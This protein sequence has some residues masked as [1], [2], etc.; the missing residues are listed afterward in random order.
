[1]ARNSFG[2]MVTP[3]AESIE[4]LL[5]GS[6]DMHIHP[7][8][9]PST[10][11]G[12]DIVETAQEAANWGMRAVVVKSFFFPT[13]DG[14][15]LACKAVPSVK[16]FGSVT[17]GYVTTG[18]LEYAAQVIETNAKLGCKVI[19]FPA[20]DAANCKAA[21][22]QPG[23]ICILDEQGAL[24]PQVYDILKVAKE[25][26]MVVCSGHMS[27]AESIAMFRAAKEMGITKLVATHPLV[28]IWPRFT[29]EE[30]QECVDCGAY[31]EHTWGMT[32]PRQGS[33]NPSNFV[34]CTHKFGA[35][36]CIMSTDLSQI[37]D[38]SPALGMRLHIAMMLQFG[39]SEDEVRLM[40]QTNPAK[41]LD[42]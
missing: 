39:C 13:T 3:S 11:R 34:D 42:L 31:I 8:P 22:K 4:N 37:T 40:C 7:G 30:L 26:G 5:H 17:I 24:K 23:G 2:M 1:M 27:F 18:G 41:L 12:Y 33:F 19:W 9:D 29:D 10:C 15:Y 28:E 20:F 36:H 35:E 38:P 16:T 25:Y 32:M 14:A 21:L 6:I